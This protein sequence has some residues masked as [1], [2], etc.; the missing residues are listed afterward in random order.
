MAALITRGRVGDAENDSNPAGRGDIRRHVS[1]AGLLLLTY[2]RS[3][4]FEGPKVVSTF[5]QLTLKSL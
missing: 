4:D 1:N 5:N 2:S 3:I